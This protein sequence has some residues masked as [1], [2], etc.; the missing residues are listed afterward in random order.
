MKKIYIVFKPFMEY[1]YGSIHERAYME[2]AFESFEDAKAYIKS[3]R[4]P[5]DYGLIDY[6]LIDCVN[7][8]ESGAK[9][10]FGW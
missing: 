9:E 1:G 8:Y 6:E 10:K 4:F 7:Y 3:R 2:G 5:D